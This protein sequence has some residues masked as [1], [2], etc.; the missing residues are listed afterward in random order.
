MRSG[1]LKYELSAN[2]VNVAIITPFEEY[3][4]SDPLTDVPYPKS[5]GPITWSIYLHSVGE[6]RVLRL[7]LINFCE[8]APPETAVWFSTLAIPYIGCDVFSGIPLTS[9]QI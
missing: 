6:D 4:K 1:T 7:W 9:Y 5:R 8:D 3:D 2:R